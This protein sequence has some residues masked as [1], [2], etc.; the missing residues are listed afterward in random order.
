MNANELW[1]RHA[2]ADLRVLIAICTTLGGEDVI[3]RL[4]EH[5]PAELVRKRATKG[6]LAVLTLDEKALVVSVLSALKMRKE[7]GSHE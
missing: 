3:D 1:A 6:G 7:C 5:W 4:V 2:T